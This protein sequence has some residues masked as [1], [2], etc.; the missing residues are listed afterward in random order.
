LRALL[1]TTIA[2]AGA[3]AHAGGLYLQEFATPTMGTAGAGAGAAAENASTAF[4]NPAGMTRIEGREAMGAGGFAK[5]FTRFD[6]SSSTPIPGSDGGDAGGAGPLLGAHY[7]HSFSDRLKA[8][9]SFLSVSGGLYNYEA[10][11]AGRYLV[12]KVKILTLNLQPSLGFRVNDWLSIGAS[13]VLMYANLDM[14]VAAPPPAGLGSVTLDRLNDFTPGFTAGVLLEPS[15][16]TRFGITYQSEIEHDLSGEITLPLGVTADIDATLPF[17][18]AVRGSMY[19]EVNDRWTVLASLR[20][21]NWSAFDK[22]IINVRVGQKVLNRNWDDTW[23]G[24]IG[25]RYRPPGAVTYQAGFGY[26][27][28]PVSASDRTPDMPID[29]QLRFAGGMRLD[30]SPKTSISGSFTVADYGSAPIDNDL[31]QGDY[32]ENWIM[33]LGASINHRFD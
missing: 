31:L 13:A 18:Q 2:V 26:D 27:S 20:W 23:G 12:E 25:L 5:G 28:N 9:V 29:R 11:W 19:H 15:A 7:V 30:V 24:S 22:Q 33:F 21:E 1:A 16:R 17:V 8:G 32:D 6:P 4:H 14:R 3:S 10:G